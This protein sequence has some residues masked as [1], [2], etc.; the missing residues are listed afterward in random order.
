MNHPGDML[1]RIIQNDRNA[2]GSQHRN[3]LLSQVSD[4]S[5]CLFLL[6][7]IGLTC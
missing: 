6:H 7:L 4:Q 1:F 2:I 5:V 3:R